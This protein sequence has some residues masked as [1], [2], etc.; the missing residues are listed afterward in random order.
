MPGLLAMPRCEVAIPATTHGAYHRL[1]LVLDGD[2][3]RVY[4]D[5][6]DQQGILYPVTDPHQL[7]SLVDGLPS[8]DR[9]SYRETQRTPM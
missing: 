4:P 1:Q 5:G 3:I 7:R 9:T 8:F 6:T 2:F